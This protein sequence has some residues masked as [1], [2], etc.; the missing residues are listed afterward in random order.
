MLTWMRRLA[1]TWFAKILFVL[2]ILSFAVWGIEDMVRNAFRDTAIARV[3]GEAIEVAEAQEAA[4]RELARIN[5]ALGGQIEADAR[6]RRAVAQQALE[7][8]VT[9][10]VL[11]QEANRLNLAVT[12][13]AVR[14][15][16]FGIEGFRGLDGRFS[17]DIFNNFLRQNDLTEARFLGLLR[18]DLAR[19]QLAGAVR[20]G[21]AAPEALARPL[22]AWQLERRTVALVELAFADAP[23]PDAP[24]EAQLARFHENNPQLFSTPEF[25]DVAVATMNAERLIASVEVPENEL[26]D[27]YAANRARFETPERRTLAQAILPNEEAARALA[28]AWRAGADFAAIEA[29]ARESGGSA[30][31]LGEVTRADLPVRA[32]AEAAFAAEEGGVSGPV[33]SPF[34]WHVLQVEGITPGTSRPFSEVREELRRTLA[35]E[36]AADLAFDR[37]NR[38]E[39]ALAGGTP[40]A[41]VARRYEMGFAEAR[42]D[43]QGRD[44][45][46]GAVALPVAQASRGAALRQ[47]F[48]AEP[49]R[50]PRLQEGEWGFLAVEVREVIPARLRPL[51]EVREQVEA[52]Y[53]ADAR[54]RFQEGRAAALLAATRGGKSLEEAAREAGAEFEEIGPFARQPGGGNPMPRDLLAPAFELR[55]PSGATMLERPQSF[56]VM[57][58]LSVTP[59]ELGDQGE[60]L[61]NLRRE[62]AQSVAEDLEAQFTAALRARADVRINP[63]LVDQV[64]GRGE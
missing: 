42:I 62:A 51:A 57:Q 3:G 19:Q 37:A 52:A 11:R 63:R 25:R 50:A 32:V 24:T 59:A 6:L 41:E 43:A 12:D 17:R 46:G 7:T 30:T 2:L 18:T 36:R 54:R 48:Q 21:A 29:R 49:G 23:E 4:Q 22:L 33:R 60:A 40:L 61:A 8:L 31:E 38:I 9:D 1:G 15:F 44:A 14:D 28:E 27:A 55:A 53:E 39:D 34:G 45:G 56:A 58:L 10:R 16:V 5:R 35:A 64:A 13:A 47:I 26:E 20:A